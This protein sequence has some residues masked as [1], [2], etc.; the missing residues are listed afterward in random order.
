MCFY[1]LF[2]GEGVGSILIIEV[3]NNLNTYDIQGVNLIE[4]I[5][6]LAFIL[7]KML[8]MGIIQVK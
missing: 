4:F 7:K 2:G 3:Q 1:F 5:C 8:A 6:S